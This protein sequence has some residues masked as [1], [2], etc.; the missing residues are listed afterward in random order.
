MKLEFRPDFKFRLDFKVIWPHLKGMFKGLKFKP[1]NYHQMM[2]QVLMIL[3]WGL[4]LLF[5]VLLLAK[6]F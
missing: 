5:I 4:V 6:I 1:E 3:S 2:K